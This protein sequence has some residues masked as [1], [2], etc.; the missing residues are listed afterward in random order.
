[1]P[2]IQKFFRVFRSL[3]G[4]ASQEGEMDEEFRF[5]LQKQVEDNI[6]AGMGPEEARYA[7]LRVFGG[8]E[9]IKEQ[10]RD[11]RGI[12]ISEEFWRDLKYGVRA[13][14]G[15]PGFAAAAVFSLA[16]GI[17]ANTAIF[18][19]IDA[20]MLRMLPVERP[21]ELIVLKKVH[22]RNTDD[23]FSYEAY[24]RF[25]DEAAGFASMLAATRAGALSI[26]LDG[27]PELVSRKSV[28]GS[29]FSVLG[30]R[31]V[32]GRALEP[33]DD[34][35]PDGKPMAVISHGYWQRRFGRDPRVLGQTFTF[36]G[37]AFTIVGVAP[38]EFFGET[39]GEAPDIWTP[40]A[41][42]PAAPPWL[43]T[44]HSVTW[45]RIVGRL[46]PGLTCGQ[47]RTVL[48]PIFV[49]M[50][51][52]IAAGM[53]ES[54]FRNEV[55]DTRLAIEDG[56]LGLSQLRERFS[57]PLRILMCVVG[58]VLMIA[59]ANVANLLLARASARQ[60]EI[61]VRLAIGAGRGR[62]VRQL[63]TSI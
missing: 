16:L 14:R 27:E 58:L 7:A 62:L 25:R 6:R 52:G 28:S 55:L 15:S 22:P 49:R 24:L 44:G 11:A 33:E 23:Q 46:A 29:Y 21:E 59:C 26:L 9:Q 37:T 53:N 39:V 13:L 32:L 41:V 63:G 3:F 48:E 38:P 61:A 56:S 1:M 60:R 47:A 12:R 20:L 35:L 30:V 34:R 43:W 31:P 17:G 54:R 4:K 51:N 40:L 57:I 50:Q 19:L 8:L 2:G 10:C 5:H 36:K 18:S 45:L 42:Q